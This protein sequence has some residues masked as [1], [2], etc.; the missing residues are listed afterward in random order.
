MDLMW[1]Q[2]SKSGFHECSKDLAK[3]QKYFLLNF[4]YESTAQICNPSKSNPH[5]MKIEWKKKTI[6]K[7][8]RIKIKLNIKY[9]LVFFI[10]S[11]Y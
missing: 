11:K 6:I 2:V 5:K 1:A 3:L 9:F 10:F 7:L 8:I 4:G